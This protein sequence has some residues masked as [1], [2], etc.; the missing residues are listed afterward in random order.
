MPALTVEDPTVLPHLRVELSA[1][2]PVRRV[3]MSH[4]PEHGAGL[5]IWRPFPGDPALTAT[6]PF[7]LLDQRGPM[8]N[9]PGDAR[10]A[11]C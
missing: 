10:E 6:D 9:G 4:R 8:A 7:L 11:P 3:V 2:P 5:E 1:P